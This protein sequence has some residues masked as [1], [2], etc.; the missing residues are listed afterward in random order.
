[1]GARV[2]I[3]SRLISDMMDNFYVLQAVQIKALAHHLVVENRTTNHSLKHSTISST[4]KESWRF[5]R[6]IYGTT[7]F[8]CGGYTFKVARGNFND[9]NY[10]KSLNYNDL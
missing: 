4:G 6:T 2:I 10:R 7:F 3:L 8:I 5:S 9:F 1:M